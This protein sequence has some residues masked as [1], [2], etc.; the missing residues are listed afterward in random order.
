MLFLFSAVERFALIW[1][2]NQKDIIHLT[3]PENCR[4]FQDYY[5]SL[6][7]KIRK[8]SVLDELLAGTC[9]FTCTL[10]GNC[11]QLTALFVITHTNS[12]G[13]LTY[14]WCIIFS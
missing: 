7:D 5:D 8:L 13:L 10:K 3:L 2:A 11:T 12:I 4:E 1:S 14:P 6:Q 9:V